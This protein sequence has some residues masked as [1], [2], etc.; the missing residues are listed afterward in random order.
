MDTLSNLHR[1]SL[2][3]KAL[4]GLP[5]RIDRTYDQAMQRISDA[6]QF[7]AEAMNFISWVVYAYRPL[8][9]REIEHATATLA[10][11]RDFE[12]DDVI[13]ADVLCS[14]C[15]GLVVIDAGFVKLVHWTAQDYF[16]DSKRKWFPNAPTSLPRNC[17]TYLLFDAFLEGPCSGDDE[18]S[19]IERRGKEFPLLG[20]ASVYWGRHLRDS[21][22]SDLEE[23]A[24]EFLLSR[25]HRAT[26]AQMLWYAA[27]RDAATW[28]AKY[29]ASSLHLASFFGLES[30]VS[31][32][33]ELGHNPNIQ[34]SV[35]VTPLMYASTQGY[36][37][38][39]ARLLQA[40]A[41]IN[42]KCH[43]G[44]TSLHRAILHNHARVVEV[45]LGYKEL[46]VNA[47]ETSLSNL[48]PFILAIN[49]GLHGIVEQLLTRQDISLVSED[50]VAFVWAA[51]LGQL[52]VVKVMLR[53]PRVDIN[54]PDRHDRTALRD[55]SCEGHVE[56]VKVLLA[57]GADPEK[58]DFN[59]G[60]PL[61]RAIDCDRVT[62]VVVLLR[63][64]V[65]L[66]TPDLFGRTLVH[67]AA[68][69][70]RYVISRL[71]LDH[72]AG[73][74]INAQGH[75]GRTALHDTAYEGKYSLPSYS[76]CH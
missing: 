58:K 8:S 16:E 6:S 1:P 35:G 43:R 42:E 74:D 25:P 33:L 63:Y 56:I 31:Q 55:A 72:S 29:S 76:I 39:V 15:A 22:G 12:A 20:Y 23:I 67:G 64:G 50:K 4:E 62:V 28:E 3:M 45:L 34:D 27:A 30:I 47:I 21:P 24:M 52:E 19:A 59:G 18:S 49:N 57:A 9:V 26:A 75:D 61:L 46:D 17:L 10:G 13:N 69:N 73:I 11:Q 51:F 48:T 68:I 5:S 70:N 41:H 65:N 54:K 2:V 32:L 40:D 71:L 38:V 37:N 66:H 14:W 60:T 53:D 36:C 44:I 7:K